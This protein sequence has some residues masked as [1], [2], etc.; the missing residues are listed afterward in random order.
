MI[1]RRLSRTKKFYDCWINW[2]I[3][4]SYFNQNDGEVIC[5]YSFLNLDKD[6]CQPYNCFHPDE[7][8][9]QDREVSHTVAT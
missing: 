4:C 9:S 8:I 2:I 6:G 3:A 1:S 7:A 5:V